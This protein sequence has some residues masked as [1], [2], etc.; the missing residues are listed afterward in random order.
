VVL[1]L[2]LQ[3]PFLRLDASMLDEGSILTIAR[4]LSH[5]KSLYRDA[6][7]FVGPLTYEGL[8]LL[9]SWLGESLLLA[10]VAQ[11]LVFTGCVLLVRR[12]TIPFVG[13]RRA[14]LVG[15]AMLAVKPL[16][17]PMWTILNYAHVAML[18]LL[19]S[20]LCFC[21]FQLK[22]QLSW[23]AGA[24]LSCGLCFLA[25]QNLGAVAG[26]SVLMATLA[27][28][29][30]QPGSPLRCM[31]M[32]PL[33]GHLA[34]LG[35]GALLPV[36]LTGLLFHRAGVLGEAVR[37]AVLRPLEPNVGWKIAF[38][39]FSLWSDG[40]IGARVYT[41]L[42]G[43][44][45]KLMLQGKLRPEQGFL[46]GVL[47]VASMAA[48]LL[49]WALFVTAGLRLA[50]GARK[51]PERWIRLFLFSLSA[52]LGYLS[53]FR[54]ADWSHLVS[55]YPL[56]LMLAAVVLANRSRWVG[57]AFLAWMMLGITTGASTFHVDRWKVDTP[58]GEVYAM[59]HQA[60]QL[61]RVLG[62]IGERP[63]SEQ[64]AFLPAQPLLYFLSG[65]EMPISY[66]LVIPFQIEAPEDRR[67]A[68]QI[69]YVDRLVFDPTPLASVEG[70]LPDFAPRF[71]RAVREGF[72][73]ER[74]LSPTAIVMARRP[75][76]PDGG[77]EVVDLFEAA[78]RSMRRRWLV[79]H[80]LSLEPASRTDGEIC[81][82]YS[83][84]AAPDEEIRAQPMFDPRIWASDYRGIWFPHPSPARLRISIRD[85]FG[86]E[87]ELYRARLEAGLPPGRLFL[88]LR[89]F[90][91]AIEIAFC[92]AP[93][94]P[95]ASGSDLYMPVGFAEPRII[96]VPSHG[97]PVEVSLH[98]TPQPR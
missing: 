36:G 69:S 33:M 72:G 43:A 31:G 92:A 71:S 78:P 50:R 70:T 37:L 24:G 1:A 9:F 14:F 60:D 65:R 16:G 12:L 64:L 39:P 45:G 77:E 73:I 46:L 74:V 97:T 23:L 66:D 53:I 61:K 62:W 89:S 44:L 59:A 19:A 94:D 11:A 22:R 93:E 96:R 54:R 18:L 58:R 87:H 42:P 7:T 80:V 76:K 25:Q 10:R 28:R 85:E 75:A 2:A 49:P 13:P 91:G 55:I 56:I 84:E 83:H 38:P 3:F 98:G 6:V 15:L 47:E 29:I 8:A 26:T 79:Y 30:A 32:R 90:R 4:E 86:E 34:V 95:V 40:E 5:G 21:R 57:G 17:F 52:C 51:D 27:Q 82:R 41:Y 63:D 35:G 81:F 88:P 68:E 48:Y 20:L 67:L